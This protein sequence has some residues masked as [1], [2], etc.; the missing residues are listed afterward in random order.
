MLK[1][2]QCMHLEMQFHCAESEMALP[3]YVFHN[4]AKATRKCGKIH[5]RLTTSGDIWVIHSIKYIL[6]SVNLMLLKIHAQN[7]IFRTKSFPIQN[8]LDNH[9]GLSLTVTITV[10]YSLTHS[11]ARFPAFEGHVIMFQNTPLEG[12]PGLVHEL[13]MSTICFDFSLH[14]HCGVSTCKLS[15]HH[16][17]MKH[18]LQL[19][20][21]CSEQENLIICIIL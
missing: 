3:C 19:G 4:Q 11:P 12:K 18:R 9:V 5:M 6:I 2:T 1:F 14:W 7:F 8:T 10:I 17:V 16:S 20:T 21:C 13:Y 15:L